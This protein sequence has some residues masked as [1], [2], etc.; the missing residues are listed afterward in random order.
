[1]EGEMEIEVSS[2][3]EIETDREAGGRTGIED[4][5]AGEIQSK[6]KRILKGTSHRRSDSAWCN[7]TKE[8]GRERSRC[9]MD[10]SFGIRNPFL[11]RELENLRDGIIRSN[12]SCT[13]KMNLGIG[14]TFKTKLIRYQFSGRI[15]ARLR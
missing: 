11:R 13:R 14:V 5:D 12:V 2:R 3:T 4:N 10:L 9:R 15:K 8:V 1:M 6:I 7:K